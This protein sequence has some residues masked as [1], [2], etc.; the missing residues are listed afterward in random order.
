MALF[1]RPEL[2]PR[3]VVPC[4][5]PGS[6]HARLRPRGCW[7]AN[8]ILERSLSSDNPPAEREAHVDFTGAFAPLSPPRALLAARLPTRGPRRMLTPGTASLDDV[9]P[10][11][12]LVAV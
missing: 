5:P 7:K 12:R 4:P 10:V 6:D 8:V 3:P 1:A 9:G 2:S 11:G